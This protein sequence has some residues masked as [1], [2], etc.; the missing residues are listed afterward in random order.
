MSTVATPASSRLEDLTESAFILFSEHGLDKVRMDA[1]AKHAGVTKGSLYHHFSSKKE[2]ILA[3]C[4]FYYAAWKQKIRV[5]IHPH[6]DPVKRLESA[7]STSVES[8]LL[9]RGNRVFTLEIMALA[10]HDNDLKT[11]WS[12]FYASAKRFYIRMVT[13]CFDA[14]NCPSTLL[15]TERVELMLCSME[16]IKQQA[17]FNPSPSSVGLKEKH[18][19]NLLHTLIQH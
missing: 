18:T 15:I 1:I 11:S 13:Q 5:A 4:D 10:L 12:D 3:A 6:Q 9:N 7:I 8:C 16:G 2:I 19:A 14:D 17:Y